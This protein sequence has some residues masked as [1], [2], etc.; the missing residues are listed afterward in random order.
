MVLGAHG[1]FPPLMDTITSPSW[2]G[3]VLPEIS[4]MANHGFFLHPQLFPLF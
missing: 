3:E 1:I 4:E 2:Y